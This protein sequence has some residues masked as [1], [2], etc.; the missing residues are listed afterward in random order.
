MLDQRTLSMDTRLNATFTPT[1]TLELFAQPFL[2]SGRYTALKEYAAPRVGSVLLYGTDIGTLDEVR[3]AA[4]HLVSYHIDPDGSGPAP[5]FDVD[6][7]DF[8]V[9]SLRG[10]A[11]LRWEYRPGSTVFFVWTQE[12]SGSADFGD[13]ALGRD[14]GALFRDRPTNVF[15]VKASYWLGI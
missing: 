9:R 12:R 5:A 14:G 3:N 1:L 15:Q 4:G 13:F 2:A 11:V 7:P 6:N 8:N 10:T